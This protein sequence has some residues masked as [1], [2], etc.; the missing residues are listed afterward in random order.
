ML[1]RPNQTQLNQINKTVISEP[2]EEVPPGG[3]VAGGRV[4]VSSPIP[5]GGERGCE[6][7]G[8][9]VTPVPK[10]HSSRLPGLTRFPLGLSRY[11][12][13]RFT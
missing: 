2:R 3:L 1:K 10:V 12:K 4:S 7:M 9:H 8:R 6:G 13:R 5:R 11:P